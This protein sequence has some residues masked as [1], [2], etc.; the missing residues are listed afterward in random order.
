MTLGNAPTLTIGL[1]V[2]NGERYLRQALDSLLAQTFTDFELVISDNASTDSTPSICRE[3]A[4]MDQRIRYVQQPTNIGAG[5]NHNLLPGLARG[6]YFK[7][8]SHDD[9]YDPDLIRLCMEQFREHPDAIL[10]HA[11]DARIDPEGKVSEPTPYVLDTANP[12]PAARL[13]S[14]LRDPGGDDFYGVMRTDV[15]VRRGPHDSHFN[16]DRTFMAGLVLYGPFYQ[17]PQVLYFRREHPDRL[18]RSSLRRK[19]AGLDPK[20]ADRLRHPTARLYAEYLIGNFRAVQQAPLTAAERRRCHRE[21]VGWM[22]SVAVR[23]LRTRQL[24]SEI[25]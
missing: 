17:V 9:L 8:A 1:P 18:T 24:R 16:A 22:G 23:A 11:W 2:Y 5:P 6:R 21:V 7:W 20:R 25:Q 19:V 4:E 13:R 14:L 3:Y 15:L 12:S 10:V